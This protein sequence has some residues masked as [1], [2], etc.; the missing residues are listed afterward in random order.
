MICRG[1]RYSGNVPTPHFYQQFK[2]IDMQFDVPAEERHKAKV[3]HEII[4]AN[5]VGNHI[6]WFISA[7]GL[8]N[9]YW[10]P[11]ALVPI[12]SVTT[13]AYSLWR[14]KRA[15]KTDPWFVAVH[16]QICARY[17][18]IFSAMLGLLLVMSLLGWVG[19]TYFGM[20]DI[21][22]KAIIGG[23]GLLPVMVTVLVLIVIES[24]VLHQ[25]GQG[26]APNGIVKLYPAPADLPIVDEP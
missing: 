19:Y 2:A 1:N 24:D 12:F 13:L 3:P 9:S 20:M 25:A 8:Y 14:A 7:L 23:T 17:S 4:L 10:Q 16:W 15:L 22:V 11:L 18:R 26:K 6:L 5:L 21:A